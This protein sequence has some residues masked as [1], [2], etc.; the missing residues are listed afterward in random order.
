MSRRL[1]IT[2]SH[3]FALASVLRN[4]DRCEWSI[5]LTADAG[6]ATHTMWIETVQAQR[7]IVAYRIAFGRAQMGQLRGRDATISQRRSR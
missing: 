1:T 6:I 3:L 2:N 4:Q 5:G 7:R